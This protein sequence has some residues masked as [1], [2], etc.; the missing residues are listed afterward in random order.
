MSLANELDRLIVASG[1]YLVY[2]GLPALPV[3]ALTF[4]VFCCGHDRNITRMHGHC[5]LGRPNIRGVCTVEGC[6]EPHEAKG[7]CKLHYVKKNYADNRAA[8][9]AVQAQYRAAHREE[10][11]ERSAAWREA[12]PERQRQG[13]QAWYAAH[14]D[15]VREYKRRYRVANRDK[16]RALNN[17]RKAQQ[18]NVEV[19]DLTAQEWTEIKAL[20]KHRC[21]YCGSKP[22]VL[23]M[24]HVVPLS[25]G[26][27]HTA[28]NIVPACQS[29]NSRK[30]DREAPAHQPLLV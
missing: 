24:D 5:Q 30:N 17:K 23:T 22:V 29:C 27:H 6:D 10:S 18:R 1:S 26:G 13:T 2:G 14:A 11:R 15:Q 4:G 28:S 8:R 20:F 12:N 21:A 25:K 3:L 19:N 7:L 16:I 9:Q